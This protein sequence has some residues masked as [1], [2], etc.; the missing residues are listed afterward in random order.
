MNCA[1]RARA[2]GADDV[3]AEAVAERLG[4]HR[5]A[6]H[7]DQ[8]RC[9]ATSRAYKALPSLGLRDIRV[10][11]ALKYGTRKRMNSSTQTFSGRATCLNHTSTLESARARA[12]CVCHGVR[13][14]VRACVLACLRACVRACV[15]SCV[16]AS[17]THWQCWRRSATPR[18]CATTTPRDSARHPPP[19][20]LCAQRQ[21]LDTLL[22]HTHIHTSV[23]NFKESDRLGVTA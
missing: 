17:N 8:P 4:V 12:H 7:D 15:R 18:L 20:P 3:G 22:V 23:H 16:R 13:A 9:A 10:I 6:G 5:A 21:L 11:W 1:S 14:C 19:P 2:A